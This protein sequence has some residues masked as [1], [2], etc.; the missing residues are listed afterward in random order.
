MCCDYEEWTDGTYNCYLYAGGKTIKTDPT[1]FPNEYFSNLIF[2]HMKDVTG[3]YI[4]GAAQKY[5]I[6]MATATILSLNI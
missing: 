1:Q 3:F 6:L 5:S 2:R 4:D